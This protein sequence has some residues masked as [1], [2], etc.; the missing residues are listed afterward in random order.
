MGYPCWGPISLGEQGKVAEQREL[1][2]AA[3][4]PKPLRIMRPPVERIATDG[5]RRGCGNVSSI[6]LM[7]RSAKVI[8]SCMA[9]FDAGYGCPFVPTCDQRELPP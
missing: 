2:R 4:S 9:Q 5:Y 3:G 7:I 8:A 1:L 6:S